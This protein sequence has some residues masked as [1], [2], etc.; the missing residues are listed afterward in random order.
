MTDQFNNG[1]ATIHRGFLGVA[2]SMDALADHVLD[3]IQERGEDSGG[4]AIENMLR[5]F[6]D[7]QMRLCNDLEQLFDS[8]PVTEAGTDLDSE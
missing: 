4:L 1:C 5:C 3:L 7:S 2:D 6:I 8:L